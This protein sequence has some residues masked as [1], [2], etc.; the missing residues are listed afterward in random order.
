MINIHM[1]ELEKYADSAN[2]EKLEN[3]IY[4]DLTGNAASNARITLSFEL[5]EGEDTQYPLEDLLDKYRIHVS[6]FLE[7]QN[8]S[9]EILILEFAGGIENIRLAASV[10]GNRVYNK[11]VTGENGEVYV[12]LI[13]E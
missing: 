3:G 1:V 5:E 6:D 11:D 7:S 13:I 9:A 8:T 2:F 10:V 4:K 12:D